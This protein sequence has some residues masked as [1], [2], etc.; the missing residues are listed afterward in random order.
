MAEQRIHIWTGTSNKTEEQ[1]YKYF[2]QSKFIKDYH[3][4]KTDE[5][6]GRN[7]PDLNLRSQFSKAIDKQYD[8]DVDWITVYYSRKKMSV[9]AA[10]EELPIWN[11]QT[12]VE[13]YQACVDKGIST[14][15]AILSYADA[16]LIID[17]PLGNYNDMTY[18]GSFNIP[19]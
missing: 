4:F 7:A 19:V 17:K 15:N 3:R 9:Q 6:Y 1:F 10:I 18:I 8:Y 13:I 5:T 14:V 11:D 12:E 2:D 16:E